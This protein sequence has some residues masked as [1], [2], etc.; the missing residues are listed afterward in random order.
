MRK[1]A[2]IVLSGL[3]VCLAGIAPAGATI[4]TVTYNGTV[5]SG[6][7]PIGFFHAGDHLDGAAYKAVYVFDTSLGETLNSPGWNYALG[8]SFF[9]SPSPALSATFTINNVSLDFVPNKLG[10]IQGIH[11]TGS[12]I[13][14]DIKR[15]A[16]L[17]PTTETVN[18]IHRL[19]RLDSLFPS[20]LDGPFS[21]TVDSK[22]GIFAIVDIE[23]RNFVTGMY[24]A[25]VHARLTPT[26][27]TISSGVPE[28]S[29]WAMMIL[30]FAGIGYGV[31]RRRKPAAVAA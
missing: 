14:H 27:V 15:L 24:S 23:Y 10:F 2:L 19:D 18:L 13:Q 30:G 4:V 17:G 25:Y 3:T 29:T 28:P 6:D 26:N 31:Y 20:S 5:A 12:L 16:Q 21:H 22:D 1:F 8:G 9:G 11:D 7:D